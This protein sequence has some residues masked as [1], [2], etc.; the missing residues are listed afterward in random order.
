MGDIMNLIPNMPAL[1]ALPENL[2]EALSLEQLGG[3]LGAYVGSLVSKLIGMIPAQ[4]MG[5]YNTHKV[6][7]LL[8]V[9][10]V[11]GLIAME[12]YRFFRGI[13]Y[14]GSAFLFGLVGFWYLS[15]MVEGMLKPYIPGIVDY[16][17]A[18][19]V[20]CA[21]VALVLC[22]VAFNFVL[23]LLG[24]GVG[25]FLG[26]GIIYGFIVSYFS[27][28]LFLQGDNVKKIVGGIIAVIVAILFTLMFKFLF[29]FLTSFGCTVGAA[30][31]LQTILVPGGDENVKV[32]F[33]VLGV[34]AGIFCIIRAKKEE[35]SIIFSL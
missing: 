5:F 24:G 33:I 16:H 28:L 2:G 26:S 15:P 34:A 14:A 12:G 30:Y 27:S 29:M 35:E 32:A 20:A 3:H 9:I 31:L 23:M 1:P 4:V 17:V 22:K 6:L 21:V 18:V 10:C 19:A 13:V 25:Y 8:A 11:L 7:C